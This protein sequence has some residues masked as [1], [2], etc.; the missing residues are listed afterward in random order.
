MESHSSATTRDSGRI[1]PQDIDAEKSLLGAI[2]LS[3]AAFP[4]ISE[5][6]KSQD[7]YDKNNGLIFIIL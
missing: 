2:L 7:F 4:E 3:D 1:P 5:K 6:V